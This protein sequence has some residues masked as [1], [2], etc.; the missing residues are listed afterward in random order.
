MKDLARK[1]RRREEDYKK[2]QAY[3]V[4]LEKKAREF[5]DVDKN[6]EQKEMKV[7]QDYITNRFI[8]EK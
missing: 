5:N 4:S 8:T 7:E 2:Q 6:I 3:L 1:S